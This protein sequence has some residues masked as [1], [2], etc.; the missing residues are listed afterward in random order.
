[1]DLHAP[2]PSFVQRISAPAWILAA[3][4]LLVVSTPPGAA[5]SALDANLHNIAFLRALFA[6]PIRAEER[7]S[8]LLA[9]ARHL[10]P[11]HV[12]SGSSSTQSESALLRS[13]FIG[14]YYRWHDQVAQAAQWYWQA[15]TAKP[16]PAQQTSLAYA[17]RIS[18]SPTGDVS[19]DSFDTL[20]RWQLDPQNNVAQPV[21]SSRD[22]ISHIAYDNR[23]NARD[24]FAISLFPNIPIGYHRHLGLRLRLAP[25]TFITIETKVDGEL[26]RQVN[27]YQGSGEWETVRIPLAG[28]LLNQIK[29]GLGEPTVVESAPERYEVWLDWLRLEIP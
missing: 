4:I 28:E 20:E 25:D 10:H 14:E 19:I 3:A 29:I 16:V 11:D 24:I 12:G 18:L 27:Y 7:Q 26:T 5:L 13:F 9:Y 1:M 17:P 6:D 8:A 23:P 22:G 2:K 15:A 21:L